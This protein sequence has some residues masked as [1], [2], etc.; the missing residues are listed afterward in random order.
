MG[1]TVGHASRTIR[2]NLSAADEDVTICTSL[3]EMRPIGGDSE[4]ADK[5]MAAFSKWLGR[6]P[7][8]PFLSAKLEERET[9]ITRTGGTRYAVEPNVNDGKGGL[10]DLHTLFWIA[11]FAYRADS[12][13]DIVEKGILRESEAR[14]F[15]AAQ[16]FLWTVRCHLHI[17]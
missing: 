5:M 12:I 16:R 8:A 10:R 4:V 2:Q 11:K 17:R 13:I 3:L 7:A 6:Q 15:A 9:R 14:R 1:L